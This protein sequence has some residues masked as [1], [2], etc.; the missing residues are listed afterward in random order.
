M[1]EFKKFISTSGKTFDEI[2]KTIN[3]LVNRAVDNVVDTVVND[4][5]EFAPKELR[6]EVKRSV[7]EVRKNAAEGNYKPEKIPSALRSDSLSAGENAGTETYT[8]SPPYASRIHYPHEYHGEELSEHEE[9][10]LDKISRMRELEIGVRG[11]G[12]VKRAVELTMAEQGR[13][14][15]D[16]EDDFAR[17]AFCAL[18]QPVYAAM[19]NSQL[20]TFFTW[21]TDA[22]RGKFAETDKPYVLLYCYELLNKVGAESSVEAFDKLLETWEGCRGF[23]P[24]LNRLMPRWLKDFYA[25]NDVAEKYP[26]I[27]AVLGVPAESGLRREFSEIEAGDY[28]GKFD[29]LADNSAYDI[30]GSAFYSKQTRPLIEAALEHTLHALDGYFSARDIELAELVCG[31]LKKDYSWVPF[32]DAIVNLDTADGFRA[33]KISASERYCIKRGEPALELFDFAPSKGFIGYLL[34]SVEARLRINTGFGRR[35]VP[36]EQMVL[37]DLKNRTRLMEAVSSPEFAKIIP[38]AVD[39]YCAKNGIRPAPKRK[40]SDEAEFAEYVAPKVEIDVSKLEEIRG[41]SDEIARK[42]I[43]DEAES[44]ELDAERMPHPSRQHDVADQE[45]QAAFDNAAQIDEDEFSERI[46]EYK[47]EFSPNEEEL[48]LKSG[49]PVF[50]E[51]DSDWQ[52]FANELI[53]SQI[54]V[55]NAL[56]TGN[57]RAYCRERDILPET[58]FEEINTLSL[59]AFGDVVIEC[60]TLVED[61]AEDI[62]RIVRAA[63]GG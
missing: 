2:K 52:S 29:F 35:I 41:R 7:R 63:G 32:K 9:F 10:I 34:K 8:N 59:D 11:K 44:G 51:L 39:E 18:P 62:A 36:K 22:R 53:P 12:I 33:V 24:Y 45:R 46:D 47:G 14:M 20:R 37:N 60:G 31:K 40:P 49:N 28:S 15:A 17:R 5:T 56:L 38:R 16:V 4:V 50:E 3:E 61:Y 13:F 19:S 1:G 30:K 42:L 6:R 48:P 23:A 55:L 43:L 54:E 21:R 58:A 25:F 26:D 57:V 27:N